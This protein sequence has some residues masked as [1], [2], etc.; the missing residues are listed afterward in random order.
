MQ[1][2]TQTRV[3]LTYEARKAR[4]DREAKR[5][6]LLE[7]GPGAHS[8]DGSFH[9]SIPDIPQILMSLPPLS[10]PFTISLF[11]V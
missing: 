2:Y 11:Q 8:S 1:F 9:P 6:R 10:I 7:H 5:A 3:H 4:L